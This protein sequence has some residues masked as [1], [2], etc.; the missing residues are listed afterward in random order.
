MADDATESMDEE[1]PDVPDQEVS[2]ATQEPAPA[3]A[4]QEVAQQQDAWVAFRQLPQFQGVSDQ[5]IAVRL[6]ETIKR[7]QLA[8]RA[9]QQ[10]QSIVP[11]ASEYLSNRPLYEQW[12]QSQSQAR[13]QQAPQQ[14]QQE[15]PAWWSPPK[16]KDI[17]RQY[18][19]RDQN[20]REVIAEGAPLEAQHELAAYQ[21]YKAEFAR[22]FLD[23]PQSTL[24]P[25]I[26]KIV[27]SRAQ[28][29]AQSQISG[30]KEESLVQQIEAENKDWLYDQQGHVSREGLLVQKYIEDA[31]GLGISGAQA[32]WDYA[33]AMVER[34]LALAN[35]Q[36]S[37]QQQQ[38]PPAQPAAPA[39]PPAAP[40]QDT[41]QR[42]MEFLRQQA[43]RTP[44]RRANPTTES[45]VPQK[46]MSFADRM[47]A[48]LQ[49]M[50]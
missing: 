33:T 10:Y 7:E 49:G 1:L 43:S 16:V 38:A 28:E 19:T 29:I 8:S 11:A 12:K 6:Q 40:Q 21:A 34:E 36:A 9:L 14:Q 27:A 50:E 47:F 37:M 24:G 18:L 39:V 41:A 32:R 46:P 20:G 45:R 4:T 13:Q 3:A 31:R 44:T 22:K 25:M 17:Y 30:L 48:N 23:D 15:E 35:L 2:T 5:E 42:N 26:E